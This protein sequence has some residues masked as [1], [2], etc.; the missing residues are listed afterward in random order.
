MSTPPRKAWKRNFESKDPRRL[1]ASSV[2]A[3]DTTSTNVPMLRHSPLRNGAK[4]VMLALEGFL[5][6]K[7]EVFI[8]DGEGKLVQDR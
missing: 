5:N 3:N 8:L 6:L 4:K 1:F 7:E 2:K